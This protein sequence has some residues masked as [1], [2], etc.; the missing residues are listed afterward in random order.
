MNKN[1]NLR[2]SRIEASVNILK[3]YI[4]EKAKISLTSHV[5]VTELTRFEISNFTT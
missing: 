3:F 5:N 2:V 4:G 1:Y